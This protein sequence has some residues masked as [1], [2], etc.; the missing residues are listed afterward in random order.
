M[1]ESANQWLV[2]GIVTSVGGCVRSGRP[3]Q[4]VGVG[5]KRGT[6]MSALWDIQESVEMDVSTSYYFVSWDIA[7]PLSVAK[8]VKVET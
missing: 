1:V 8:E 4:E 3:I 6:R 5:L 2:F 7:S